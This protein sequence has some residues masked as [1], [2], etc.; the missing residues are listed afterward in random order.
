MVVTASGFQQRIQDSPATI[1]VIPRQQLE[2]RAYRDVTD[3]LKDVPGV[4]VTGGAS[5]SDIS[6]RGMS[7]KYT[8]ILI[9]GKRVDTRGTRPNSD[10]AGIEQVG[11]RHCR[12]LNALKWYA[13]QCLHSMA[14]TPWAG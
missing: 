8:L 1:S 5:S 14:P 9:D 2:T 4:V 7:S 11:C 6:I 10:N 3:A 12:L 13:G